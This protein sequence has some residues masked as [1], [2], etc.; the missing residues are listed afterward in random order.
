MRMSLAKAAVLAAIL[1]AAFAIFSVVWFAA[2]PLRS[3]SGALPPLTANEE[4]IRDDLAGYVNQLSTTIGERNMDHPESLSAA[5]DYLLHTLGQ[6]GFA[7]STYQYPVK[8][9]FVKNIEV[10]V[11][12]LTWPA[13]NVIVGAH[14]DSVQGSPGANDNA[15]GVAAA[16]E[17]A[18]LLKN[19]RPD[20][21]IRF[22][23]FVNEEPPYFQTDS[24]GSLVYA[25]NLRSQNVNVSA[26]ISLDTIGYYSDDEGSQRYPAGFG[27]LY[28]HVGNFIAFVG[29]TASRDL[30]R[31]AVGTFRKSARFPSEGVA[32]P[33]WV[34]GIGWSDQWSFWRQGYHGIMITDTA[35]F[36][37]PYY[38]RPTD[39]ADKV[40][41]DRMAR[42]VEGLQPVILRLAAGN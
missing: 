34:T 28:P 27:L 42:V 14:Y 22:V 19:S 31:S 6:E 24:M 26:M 40:Q 8:G 32:A 2:M 37:Y 21:T 4:Q 10:R 3:Y 1:L 13:R 39:T 20:Q 30:V 9:K 25:K 7:L 38:H 17:L 23:F 35:L 5:T 18:R 12:G 33:A 11:N 16:L 36:R 29:D 15:S 41:F